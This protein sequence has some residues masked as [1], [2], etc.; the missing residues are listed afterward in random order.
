MKRLISLFMVSMFVMMLTGCRYGAVVPPGKKVI[1]LSADGETAIHEKG[2]YKAWGRDRLYFVDQKLKS[3]EEKMEILC[4]DDINMSVDVKCVL[5]FQ[6]DETSIDFIK[7]KVPSVK[8]ETGSEIAGYELSL[9]QFYNMTVKDIVRS[10]ARN[11]IS[12]YET[13]N[14]R[15]NRLKIEGDLSK[16]VTDRI[17]ALKFPLNISAV[18]VSNLDYPQVV[19]DQRNAIKNAQLEDQ[20]AA[21]LAEAAMAEAQRRAGVETEEAKVRM[22]KAQAQ[23]DENAI[24]AESLTPEYLSWKQLEVMQ[25][26]STEMAKGQNNVVFIMPYEA[27][28]QD[29]MN[30]AMIRE[31]VGQLSQ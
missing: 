8:T 16:M 29:T 5:S 9:D 22:I 28:S 7:Q 24:L 31:S 2:V 26:V 10:S 13:D 11:I 3:F 14:I 25:S 15:P 6:V 19:I 30:T 20:R 21:A 27:I 18:L 23:A 1:I 17:T 4:E 12:T